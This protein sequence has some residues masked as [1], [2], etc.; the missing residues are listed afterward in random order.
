MAWML[1]EENWDAAQEWVLQ[2]GVAIYRGDKNGRPT[3]ARF[4][5]V[6]SDVMTQMNQF[7]SHM[8]ETT[9]GM[10][11]ERTIILTALTEQAVKEE[12]APD[13]VDDYALQF[14]TMRR[15]QRKQAR[16]QRKGEDA[17]DDGSEVIVTDDHL[18]EEGQESQ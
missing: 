11:P 12:E 16:A 15:E 8:S 14:Y 9:G 17:E 7:A 4:M 6:F 10:N 2:Y 3:G 5:R 18:I 1:R 13:A